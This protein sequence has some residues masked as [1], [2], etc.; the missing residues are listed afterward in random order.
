MA[1]E[2]T[3][4]YNVATRQFCGP[5]AKI[6]FPSLGDNIHNNLSL[7]EANVKSLQRKPLRA[8]F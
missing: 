6:N 5:K 1:E 8:Q 7:I 2:D 3:K 4:A